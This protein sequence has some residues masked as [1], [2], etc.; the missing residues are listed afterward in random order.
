MTI[1]AEAAIPSRRELNKAAT[2]EAIATAALELLRAKGM[3]GFTADDVANAAGVS[4]RTFFNYF[5]SP[6]AA[7]ASFTQKYLDTVIEQ[8]LLRPRDEAL[9]ES[10]QHALTAVE[11]KDL[12]T[13]AETFALTQGDAQLSRFQLEAWDNC[14]SK[15]I[16]AIGSRL[17][18]LDAAGAA[19]GSTPLDANGELYLHALVQSVIACGRAAVE[20]W[21]RRHGEDISPASLAQLRELLVS[22]IG[23]LRTG[24]HS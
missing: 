11:P 5:S 14:S 3:N 18:G 21:F 10:A 13:L 20:V 8:L 12:A 17:G 22:A 16:T 15:I 4:R 24:F 2:R 9:L 7:I 6:E 19:P 1:V 23:H